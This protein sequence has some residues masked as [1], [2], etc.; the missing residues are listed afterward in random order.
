MNRQFHYGLDSKW[1][2]FIQ[3]ISFCLVLY[4]YTRSPFPALSLPK[5][6]CPF[7][8]GNEINVFSQ[9]HTAFK[10]H[11]AILHTSR[12]CVLSRVANILFVSC[13][14]AHPTPRLQ[15]LA[16][17]GASEYR[18]GP[19]PAHGRKQD[20]PYTCVTSPSPPCHCAPS[21]SQRLLPEKLSG[22]ST[23]P[24]A[25]TGTWHVFRE[26]EPCGDF[27]RQLIRSKSVADAFFP[28]SKFT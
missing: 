18:G 15:H 23:F 27:S 6:F 9:L 26:G 14:A 17:H 19:Q 8:V 7:S 2:S 20:S 3:I 25:L 10:L 16:G 11:L 28:F 22:I 5:R 12:R 4:L 24:T 13:S 1:E 21:T